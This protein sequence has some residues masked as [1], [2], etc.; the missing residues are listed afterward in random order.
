MR[1]HALCFDSQ[2]TLSTALSPTLAASLTAGMQTRGFR[3]LTD[4][5][6]LW[7]DDHIIGREKNQLTAALS[8]SG[9]ALGAFSGSY[10]RQSTFD[11]HVRDR[12]GLSWSKMFGR[13]SVSLTLQRAMGGSVGNNDQSAYLSVNVPLGRNAS[14]RFYASHDEARGLRTG[15]RVNQQLSD[16]LGYTLAA[17]R[18]P[19]G[20]TDLSGRVNLLPRYAQLDLGLARRQGGATSY[21]ASLRGGVAFH[22]KGVTLSPYALRDTFGVLK[23]GDAAGIKVRTPA[24]PVWTDARGMA[25]A[26][27]LPAY[28]LSRLEVDTASLPRNVDVGNGYREIEAGRG[29][30]HWLP[31]EVITVRRLLLAA[32]GADG[33]AVPKGSGVYDAQKNYVTTVLEGGKIFLTDASALADLHVVRPDES[34][35]A[36]QFEVPAQADTQALFETAAAQCQPR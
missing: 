7:E 29:S 25:V 13:T 26:S 24:G 23:L 10:S 20:S 12:A 21:D 30:V 27:Q 18:T 6:V 8:W 22:G 9:S 31:F 11:G 5:T 4:T 17:E 33:A 14:S 36:L 15:A 1:A 34:T 3:T 16:T 35:C 32:R 19:E 2:A 28:R